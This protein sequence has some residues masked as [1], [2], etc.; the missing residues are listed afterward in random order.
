M[1]LAKGK[2]PELYV[3]L[4]EFGVDVEV[5]KRVSLSEDALDVLYC[6][7]RIVDAHITKKR[8]RLRFGSL[9]CNPLA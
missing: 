5:L 3:R 8:Q 1:L 6:A 9:L 4:E 7:V 2:V